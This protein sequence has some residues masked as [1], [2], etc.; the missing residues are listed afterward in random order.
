MVALR[1][2]ETTINKIINTLPMAASSNDAA[3]AADEPHQHTR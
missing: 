3:I 2:P 1:G